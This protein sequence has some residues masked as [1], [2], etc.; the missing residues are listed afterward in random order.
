MKK[1]LKVIVADDMEILAR[2]IVSVVEQNQN[3]DFVEMAKNGKEELEKI[4]ELEPDIVFT[5][6]RMPE[7]TGVEVIEKVKTMKQKK[8]PLFILVTSDRG[9]DIIEKARKLRF[10]VE[11]KPISPDK[12]NEYIDEFEYKEIENNEEI[13][14]ETLKQETMKKEGLFRRLFKNI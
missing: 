8:N 2:Q 12:I 10:C 9:I 1:N 14:K 11:Y 4:L 3:V 7:M 6:M 13:K 5:D